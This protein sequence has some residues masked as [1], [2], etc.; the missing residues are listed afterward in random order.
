MVRAG[1][2]VYKQMQNRYIDEQKNLHPRAEA[3]EAQS[4][5]EEGKDR[6][7][8]LRVRDTRDGGRRAV[9]LGNHRT[10]TAFAVSGKYPM[11]DRTGTQGDTLPALQKRETRFWK[12]D[13]MPKRNMNAGGSEMRMGGPR[14]ER[15]RSE[16]EFNLGRGQRRST[17]APL[18]NRLERPALDLGEES[19]VTMMGGA[20]GARV[21]RRDGPDR[22]W[23]AHNVEAAMRGGRLQERLDRDSLCEPR[24]D[25]TRKYFSDRF[26]V[27]NEVDMGV[28]NP[29]RE[30]LPRQRALYFEDMATEREIR[31]ERMYGGYPDESPGKSFRQHWPRHVNFESSQ[32][33][34]QT[35]DLQKRSY[36]QGFRQPVGRRSGPVQVRGARGREQYARPVGPTGASHGR[37]PGHQFKSGRLG[38]RPKMNLF[39]RS[40]GQ[41]ECEGT[42]I[43]PRYHQSFQRNDL[44][45]HRVVQGHRV[46][47]PIQKTLQKESNILNPHVVDQKKFISKHERTTELYRQSP[48]RNQSRMMEI[49]KQFRPVESGLKRVQNDGRGG[50]ETPKPDLLELKEGRNMLSVEQR[51]TTPQRSNVQIQVRKESVYVSQNVNSILSPPQNSDSHILI[52]VN[53]KGVKL[54]TKDFRPEEGKLKLPVQ[55]ESLFIKSPVSDT[56]HEQ[57]RQGPRALSAESQTN[58]VYKTNPGRDV[59]NSQVVCAGPLGP[60]SMFP[61]PSPLIGNTAYGATSR[62]IM[63]REM[64]ARF[65][66]EMRDQTTQTE[67]HA[68]VNFMS[69]YNAGKVCGLLKKER[70]IDEH[71]LIF[72]TQKRGKGRPHKDKSNVSFKMLPTKD[73][74]TMIIDELDNIIS[75]FVVSSLQDK[76]VTSQIKDFSFWMK[77]RLFEQAKTLVDHPD[78]QCPLNAL[79]ETTLEKICQSL[80]TR[81]FDSSLSYSLNTPHATFLMDYLIFHICRSK[82]IRETVSLNFSALNRIR[83]VRQLTLPLVLASFLLLVS[84]FLT[85]S[86]IEMLHAYM[87]YLF[88]EL[89]PETLEQIG[90]NLQSGRCELA[91]PTLEGSED[92]L[93]LA[94]HCSYFSEKVGEAYERFKM[95]MPFGATKSQDFM[96]TET[97]LKFNSLLKHYV[98]ILELLN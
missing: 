93:E 41:F 77:K 91:L 97:A 90:L 82:L 38:V 54:M 28:R 44:H 43:I 72:M 75:S 2:R 45:E 92:S 36:D 58:T 56:K 73:K 70:D 16:R 86:K 31:G 47:I 59:V 9:T 18:E 84:N 57:Y 8:G 1:C 60:K 21:S 96:E 53:N 11:L 25:R 85:P 71:Q 14:Y 12:D 78:L 63:E 89:F 69:K 39:E 17:A 64:M 98:G 37:G 46:K 29:V 42:S 26:R 33:N 27:R 87:A 19:T 76:A 4:R 32:G 20:H 95:D 10:R 74:E 94:V 51:K 52:N 79:P 68:L 81:R 5:D 49:G 34:V 65:R 66:V 62:P 55:I 15:R 83:N 35:L 67:M 23:I 48:N 61:V 88:A 24:S 80:L 6:R 40:A 22:T 50:R 3:N 30:G 7:S 13:T